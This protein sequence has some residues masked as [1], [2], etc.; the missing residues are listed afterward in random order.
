MTEEKF[1]F[2]SR[3]KHW[4]WLLGLAGLIPFVAHTAAVLMMAP[5]FNFVAVSSQIL[6][7]ALIRTFVGGLHWGVLLVAGDAFSRSQIILRLVWSVTPSLYAFW[8]AQITHPKPLL[9]L[10]G[11]LVAALIVDAWLYSNSPGTQ[12]GQ[13]LPLRVVLTT[14]ASLCLLVTWAYSPV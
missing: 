12:L 3:V 10:A 7:A 4:A 9:Y 2:D 1:H 14:V 6:Y 11:G 5:P 8:F 13:F